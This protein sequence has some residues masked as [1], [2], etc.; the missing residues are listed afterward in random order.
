MK[1]VKYFSPKL[2]TNRFLNRCFYTLQRLIFCVEGHKT[3]CFR[4]FCLKPK[5]EEISNFRPNYH[6]LNA[7]EK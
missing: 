4:L 2:W 5:Y 1:E 6:G 7:L 3:P